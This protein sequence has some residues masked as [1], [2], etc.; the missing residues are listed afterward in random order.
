MFVENNWLISE[1]RYWNT[2]EILGLYGGEDDG[3]LDSDN[4]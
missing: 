3:A 1:V 4:L 2:I